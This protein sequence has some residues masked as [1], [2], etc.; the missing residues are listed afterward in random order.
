VE[1]SVESHRRPLD[2]PYTALSLSSTRGVAVF[3]HIA[4]SP[5]NQEPTLAS[6]C[7]HRFSEKETEAPQTS[8][9]GGGRAGMSSL[10]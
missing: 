1:L 6:F 8:S 4:Y 10:P 2:K 7:K 9:D 3:V 5:R